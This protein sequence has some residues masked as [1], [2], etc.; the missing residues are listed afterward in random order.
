ML[1]RFRWYRRLRGGRWARVTSLWFGWRWFRMPNTALERADEDWRC[2]G[3]AIY[4]AER[5]MDWA[6]LAF[7]DQVSIYA[8]RESLAGGLEEAAELIAGV[9]ANGKA[10]MMSE[11]DRVRKARTGGTR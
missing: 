8:R 4:E 10:H 1:S 6:A 9:A 7:H 3:T 2:V 5:A 11:F